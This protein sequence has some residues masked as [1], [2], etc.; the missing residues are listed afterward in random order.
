CRC[1]RGADD[2]LAAIRGKA[3]SGRPHSAQE[4]L[5]GSCSL[6][7]LLVDTTFGRPELS[8]SGVCLLCG[9]FHERLFA[10]EQPRQSCGA[11]KPDLGQTSPT[12]TGVSGTIRALCR[13]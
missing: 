7:M 4:S 11:S 8:T 12:R 9:G 10:S 1:A 13:L 2:E 5:H 3:A 6:G